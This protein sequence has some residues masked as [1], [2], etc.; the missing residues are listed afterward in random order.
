ME[1]QLAALVGSSPAE[2]AELKRR[3]EKCLASELKEIAQRFK[4][5]SSVGKKKGELIENLLK[6]GQDGALDASLLV[7]QT[8]SVK[9]DDQVPELALTL[10][11]WLMWGKKNSS[12][13]WPRLAH[14]SE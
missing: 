3:L 9:L 5:P 14:C 4:L 13:V 7:D 2:M 10:E 1:V 12:S 11:E 8:Q 6:L